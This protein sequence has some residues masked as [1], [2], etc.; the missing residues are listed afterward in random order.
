MGAFTSSLK[1]FK[2]NVTGQEIE[3]K[4][5]A[6]MWL[7]LEADYGIKQGNFAQNLQDSEALTLA[8]LV[9]A[10]LKANKIETTLDEILENTDDVSLAQF[11]FAYNEA[12]FGGE[13]SKKEVLTTTK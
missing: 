11:Y 8:K 7:F 13:D 1:T 10:T 9:H 3:L 2:T 4:I 6:G 5:V 12:L